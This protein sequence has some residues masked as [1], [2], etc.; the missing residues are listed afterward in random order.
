MKSKVWILLLV[1]A[2]VLLPACPPPAPVEPEPV[3]PVEPEPVEPVPVLRVGVVTSIGGLGDK[4]F[5][6]FT[7]AGVQRAVEELGA[8]VDVVE[9]AAIGDFEGLLREFAMAGKHEVILAIGFLQ[10]EALAIVAPEFPDQ[11]FIIVDGVVEEP[12]VTALVFRENEGSF[13]VGVL[14]GM[15]TDTGRV[16]F[17]GGMDVPIIHRFEA[18]FVAGAK[19]AN[20]DVVVDVTYAGTFKDP[21]IGKEHAIAHFGRG[22]DIVFPAAGATALGVFEAAAEF[23]KLAIGV[24]VD[25][26]HL[27]PDY[28]VASMIKGIDVAAY[29]AILD[30]LKGVLEPG[31]DEFGLA[32]G[33]PGI[34]FLEI[35]HVRTSTVPL[36]AE[37]RAKVIEARQMIIDGLI[38]VPDAR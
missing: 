9:P 10:T 4:S 26:A 11:K 28:I 30:A 25:Q 22:V 13:L 32:E 33:V 35:D 24:D 7:F 18:G 8:E 6:D 31:I 19:W 2:L 3:E 27:A 29:H 36:P 1:A 21:A 5:N 34:C 23:D 12:N 15:M 16:G 37:V 38:N 20:P 14:A 17:I